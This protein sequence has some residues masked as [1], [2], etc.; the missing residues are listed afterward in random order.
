MSGGLCTLPCWLNSVIP[1]QRQSQHCRPKRLFAGGLPR[2]DSTFCPVKALLAG[3]NVEI[4]HFVRPE[5][6]SPDKQCGGIMDSENLT[7]G[8]QP[9]VE[10]VPMES[11]PGW[12]LNGKS[13]GFS[14]GWAFHAPRI[15]FDVKAFRKSEPT[16][17]R[18]DRYRGMPRLV[19]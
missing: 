8:F 13:T 5:R 12:K 6:N 1:R 14:W 9:H 7:K 18:G 3:Q 11:G 4:I 17:S 10:S 19:P 16:S 15:G 2:V